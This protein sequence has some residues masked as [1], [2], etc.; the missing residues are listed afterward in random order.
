MHC[1][2][3]QAAG[4]DCIN[5]NCGKRVSKY[6]CKECKLW[7]DDPRKNIYHWYVKKR[8]V[9]GLLEDPVRYETETP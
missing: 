1:N 4:Q 5:P 8:S 2:M 7:D 6:Y 3:V 9:V